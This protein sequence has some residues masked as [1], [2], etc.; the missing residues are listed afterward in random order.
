MPI[1]A[2]PL[3]TRVS[4]RMPLVAGLGRLEVA[5]ALLDPLDDLGVLG[6]GAEHLGLGLEGGLVG[7]QGLGGGPQPRPGRR[8]R[9]GG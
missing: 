5:V 3:T 1:V 7:Q 9:G 2:Q 8:R 6:G 4:W